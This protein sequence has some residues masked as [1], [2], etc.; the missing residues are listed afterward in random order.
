M[1]IVGPIEKHV[2]SACYDK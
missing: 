2:T 1:L